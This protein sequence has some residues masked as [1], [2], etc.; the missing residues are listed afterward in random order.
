MLT[1]QITLGAIIDSNGS[2]Q[3]NEILDYLN[4]D[5]FT[6]DNQKVWQAINALADAGEPINLIKV[7]EKLSNIVSALYIT[8]LIEMSIGAGIVTGYQILNEAQR[9]RSLTKV[10][11]IKKL[12]AQLQKADPG[13]IQRAIQH[14]DTVVN[15]L[16]EE[17]RNDS[18][19]HIKQIAEQY[20]TELNERCD[21]RGLP[22]VTSTYSYLDHLTNGF[23]PGQLIIIAGQPGM[24]KSAFV[25]NIQLRQADLGIG[26]LLFS[27]EMCDQEL[28][29]RQVAAKT[30]IDS[31]RLQS[32]KLDYEQ[33]ERATTSLAQLANLP[34]YIDDTPYPNT[35]YIKR[36]AKRMLNLDPS[37]R[38]VIIDYLQLLDMG[39][40]RAKGNR[41]EL[42]A[43][44]TRMLKLTARE[45]GIPIIVLSQL[46]RQ[47]AENRVKFGKS[48]K[49]NRP[50]ISNLRDSGAIEQDADQILFVYRESEVEPNADKTEAEIIV[51][52]CRGGRTGS[53]YLGWQGE[54]TQFY[55]RGDHIE[56]TTGVRTTEEDCYADSKQP[57]GVPGN[58]QTHYEDAE[59]VVPF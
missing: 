34:I 45:L 50:T 19:K 42:T 52:K 17:R 29:H 31:M 49:K 8:E 46:N 4:D 56:Q 24:G 36:R 6:G 2:N 30:G 25:Q 35:A 9:L 7:T 54:T 5:D 53:V 13:N 28:M 38:M 43:E 51:A 47:V 27:L 39:K 33:Q 14:I 59:D 22:G 10:E 3:L 18:L 12:G 37:I 55:E 41:N 58:D 32:G 26:S 16:L 11:K 15:E 48:V 44:A 23:G 21:K 20:Q 57:Q 1:Q 40:M